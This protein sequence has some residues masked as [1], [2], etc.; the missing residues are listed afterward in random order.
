MVTGSG[1]VSGQDIRSDFWNAIERFRLFQDTEGSELLDD[2]V[3]A[4]V[5]VRY[6]TQNDEVF[7]EAFKQ[8]RTVQ[9]VQNVAATENVAGAAVTN[10]I[11]E[12][13]LP[14][15]LWPTQRISDDDWFI[16][17]VSPEVPKPIFEQIR[18]APRTFE[19]TRANS[20]RARRRKIL[21]LLLDLR[22]GFGV[23]LPYGSIKVNN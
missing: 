2:E 17:L 14:V 23:N 11:R 18:Q 4:G 22:S 7:H 16:D 21:A 12:S 8:E 3:D 5:V 1:V 9:I 20:E 10:S 13:G 6:N 19:E 15:T